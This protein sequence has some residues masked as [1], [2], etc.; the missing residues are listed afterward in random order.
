MEAEIGS[1]HTAATVKIGAT[2]YRWEVSPKSFVTLKV[3][4]FGYTEPSTK[5][6]RRNVTCTVYVP[7]EKLQQT[8]DMFSALLEKF[9]IIDLTDSMIQEIDGDQR[10]VRRGMIITAPTKVDGAKDQPNAAIKMTFLEAV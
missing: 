2:D 10:A 4:R 5:L 3:D 9:A 8:I 6:A 7:T 1:L